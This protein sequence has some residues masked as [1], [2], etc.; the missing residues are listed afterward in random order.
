VTAH[1][2]RCV[3]HRL[4]DE[5][6]FT[7]IELL[8]ATLAGLVVSAA[9]LAIVV[10]SLHFSLNDGQRVDAD[11]Q[12][13]V[14]M[15]KVV[16]ALNSSCVVGVGISP[17]V[18]VTGTSGATGSLSAPPSSGNSITFYSSLSDAPVINNPNEIVIY[19]SSA[20]GPLDMATYGYVTGPTGTT[21]L[22]GTYS[23]TP[24]STF[25]LLPHAAAPGSTP[26][27]GSTTPIFTYSG[28]D[29]SAGTLTDQFPSSPTLG[30]TSAAATAAVGIN[31]QSQP[32]DGSNP[33]N[34]SVDLSDAVTLRLTSVSNY[35][36][37][38]TGATNV[39]PC[40]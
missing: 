2:A 28:Y 22:T 18:G 17:V 24:T 15:E 20:N 35:P 13:S 30:A 23:T 31:F 11:Q 33:A 29:P 3:G 39:S 14:A 34:G 6:G 21:G 1:R 10:T 16:Q 25:V 27:H 4:H 40:A 32:S 37:P 9:A 5:R 36:N 38:S 7:L 26:T 12:G 19:L 8:V